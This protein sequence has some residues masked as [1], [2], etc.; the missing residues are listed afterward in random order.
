[1]YEA[2]FTPSA[3]RHGF[4]EA[5]FYELLTGRYLKIRSQQGLPDVYELLGRNFAGD[6]WHVVY[7]MRERGH[8]VV[9]HMRRMTDRERRRYRRLER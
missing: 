1:M 5:D 3:F 6:H 9:F 7:R 4:S 2:T 8:M